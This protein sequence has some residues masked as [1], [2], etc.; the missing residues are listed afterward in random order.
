MPTTVSITHSCR[1]CGHVADLAIKT[2]PAMTKPPIKQRMN[3]TPT[4]P[5]S[6]TAILIAE[7]DDAHINDK[8]NKMGISHILGNA[9]MKERFLSGAIHTFG[10]RRVSH[11]PFMGDIIAAGKAISIIIIGDPLQRRFNHL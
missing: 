1:L 6:G 5:R 8:N 2:I 10:D 11:Q 3:T 9:F 4:G 7:N